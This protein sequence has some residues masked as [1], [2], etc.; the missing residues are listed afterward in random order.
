MSNTKSSIP[1]KD[2]DFNF[3]QGIIIS[4]AITNQTFWG[5][6]ATWL[7][8][9]STRQIDWTAAW[10]AYEDPASRTP[11]IV[12]AKN[13]KRKALA[14]P[15]RKLV[16]ILQ[17]DPRVT[18]DDLRAMGIVI[19]SGTRTP[20]PVAK[21]YPDYDIDSGTIRCLSIHFYDQGQKKSKAKPPGQHGAEIRWA[22]RGTPPGSL[23]ELTE[24]SF[25][26]RTPFT[27]SF[28]EGERGKTVYFCLC[29][30]NTRGEKRPWSEIQGAIIP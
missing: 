15:L 24:S 11:A 2:V 27:L 30:E 10:A 14:Q 4:T 19:P 16:K 22:V 18:D 13:E 1:A 20:S 17:S 7:H 23:K 5:L 12:F 21:T 29:W 8:E 6:D 9:L 3:A 26:T 28:D 25:D